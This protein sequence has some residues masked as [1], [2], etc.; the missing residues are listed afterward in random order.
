MSPLP[1]PLAKSQKFD[2]QEG[3]L[4]M[5]K[6]KLRLAE[7]NE[8][9]SRQAVLSENQQTGFQQPESSTSSESSTLPVSST[10]PES[11]TLPVSST[12]AESSTLSEGVLTTKTFAPSKKTTV[13]SISSVNMDDSVYDFQ[14]TDAKYSVVRRSFGKFSVGVGHKKIKR[15]KFC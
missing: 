11:S 15:G 5:K 10:L 14:P 4:R 7:E 9:N 3:I 12:L 2:Y 6:E 13:N 8:D 1:C